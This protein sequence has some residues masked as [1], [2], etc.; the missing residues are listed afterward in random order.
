MICQ[1]WSDLSF[2]LCGCDKSKPEP[3]IWWGRHPGTHCS[4]QG[5]DIHLDPQV[6][7][8]QDRGTGVTHVVSVSRH[9]S[10]L[11]DSAALAY[12]CMLICGRGT[13][14]AKAPS[15]GDAKSGA[16]SSMHL[17][18]FSMLQ[19]YHSLK[20]IRPEG[21]GADRWPSQSIKASQHH[22]RIAKSGGQIWRQSL[23]NA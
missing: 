10:S 12:K 4:L 5:V 16:A 23:F 20:W 14:Q 6:H 7:P 8:V 17:P 21:H 19:S 15:T 3:V 11:S 9:R 2:E 1:D 22:P 18:H 13:S